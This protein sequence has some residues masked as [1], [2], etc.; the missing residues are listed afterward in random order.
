MGTRNLTVVVSD[1][2]IKVAQYGQWDGYPEGQGATA[3]NF[4]RETNLDEF[5]EKL[6]NISFFTE[7]EAEKEDE[8]GGVYDRRPY[9]SRDLG[10]QILYAIRDG[11]YTRS[12]YKGDKDYTVKVD[13]LVNGFDFGYDS[14]FCE[15]V[16][17]ID[18]DKGVFEL[19]EGFNKSDNIEGLWATN[20]SQVEGSKDYKAITRVKS[21][22]LDSLPTEDEFL[23]EFS[24]DDE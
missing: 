24:D 23:N 7:E 9:L 12:S 8:M 6:K 13:K 11:K 5:K 19:Y 14:L 22:P 18:L 21:F 4:L 20:K 16:Y 15:W 3:L 10:A 17:V 1:D 2:Q